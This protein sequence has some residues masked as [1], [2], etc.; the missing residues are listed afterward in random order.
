MAGGGADGGLEWPVPLARLAEGG[1]E[2]P[3][4]LLAMVW[5]PRFDRQH[6]LEWL[7]RIG[8]ADVRTLAAM[9][10]FAHRFD[11]LAPHAQRSVRE[12]TAA[13]AHNAACL[14]SC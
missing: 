13:L 5:G 3:L 7:A 6:G 12:A 11:S 10:G 14:A 8:A 2:A 4:E 9:H 1:G